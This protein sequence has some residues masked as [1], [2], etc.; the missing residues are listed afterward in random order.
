MQDEASQLAALALAR[1]DTGGA[2]SGP[3]LDMCAGPGGK[4]RLLA[5]LAAEAR[6]GCSPRTCASTGPAWS[7]PPW[8]YAGRIPPGPSRHNR[9]RDRSSVADRLIRPGARRRPMLGSRRAPAAAGGQVAPVT[10]GCDRAG[11]ACS[12]GCSRPLSTRPGLAALS[13]TSPAR[14]TWRRPVK[15]S[16]QCWR[17]AATR[18][19]STRPPCSPRCRA[20]AARPPTAGSLSSGRTV[21]APTRSSWRCSAA[22]SDEA[23]RAAPLRGQDR[24]C[25]LPR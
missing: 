5:G 24:A 13:H 15:S 23:C 8:A 11:R 17:A 14:R 12:D 7:G 25:W 2:R 22:G 6:A 3:W 21:T 18:K 20:C 1:A 16:P 4:A 9:R 10:T 19:Y